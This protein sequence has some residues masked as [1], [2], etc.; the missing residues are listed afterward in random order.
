MGRRG[1]VVCL[2]QRVARRWAQDRHPLSSVCVNQGSLVYLEKLVSL[3]PLTSTSQIWGGRY[4]SL[5]V[6]GTF[7]QKLRTVVCVLKQMDTTPSMASA[8]CTNACMTVKKVQFGSGQKYLKQ[9]L[10]CA[11]TVILRLNPCL[12]DV[13]VIKDTQ[14]WE[15]GRR[16][17]SLVL[18]V[19][20]KKSTP[21]AVLPGLLPQLIQSS[22][23]RVAGPLTPFPVLVMYGANG[24]QSSHALL[25]VKLSFLCVYYLFCWPFSFIWFVIW[26][27]LQLP[28]R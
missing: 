12:R 4:A 3:V 1:I 22:S 24:N 9:N 2:V 10:D 17:M 7:Q 6:K 25:P 21:T 8:C 26:R 28:T 16:I 5:A 15:Y 20:L 19:V 14:S 23:C 11:W 13:S 27:I 18:P